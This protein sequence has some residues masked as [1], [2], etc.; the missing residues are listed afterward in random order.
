MKKVLFILIAIV[1][2]EFSADAQDATGT[3]LLPGGEQYAQ[4][5]FYKGASNSTAFFNVS[6][7]RAMTTL[8]VVIE[9]EILWGSWK[10]VKL[11]DDTVYDIPKRQ[12]I[13]VEFQMP[14]YSDIRNIRVSAGN[15][16]CKS[17]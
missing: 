16:V 12:T 3:C 7:D 9:A 11:Y 17:E 8:K 6:S 1:C 4:V 13:K 5:N 10:K 14:Q 2:F 15:P